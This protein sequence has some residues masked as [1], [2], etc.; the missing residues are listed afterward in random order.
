MPYVPFNPNPYF[1]RVGDCSVRAICKALDKK[2][3]DA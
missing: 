1:Q 2:W 3:E